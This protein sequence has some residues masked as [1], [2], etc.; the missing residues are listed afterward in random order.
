MRGSVGEMG[1]MEVGILSD[2]H[3][4]LVSRDGVQVEPGGIR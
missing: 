4:Q 3:F 2:A 1:A